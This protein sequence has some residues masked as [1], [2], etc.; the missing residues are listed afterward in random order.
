MKRFLL[1]ALLIAA[2]G[3]ALASTTPHAVARRSRPTPS[4]SPTPV[5]LPTATPEPPN[6]A[7]PR[8]QA[9]IR[10]NPND[11]EAM[12]ELA[13]EY[14][15][16][17]RPDLAL[18]LTQHLLQAGDKSAQVYF[19]DGYAQQAQGQLGIAVADLEQASTLDPTNV[20][21]LADLANLYLSINR[22]S[23]AERVANRA[24]TFNKTSPEAYLSLGSVYAAES[25]YDDARIQFE[26]AFALDKTSTKPLVSIAQTY[27]AQNNLPLALQAV[28][29]ALV[30][31]PQSVQVL[32]MKASLYARQHDD[33]HASEAFDD[34]AVA[35]AT[36]DQKVAIYVQKAQYFTSEHKASQALAVYQQLLS[37]YPNV[38][39]TY[40]AYGAYLA[41]TMHQVDQGMQQWRKALTLD[42]DNE[43]AL[44]DMGEYELQHNRPVD[45]IAYLKHLVS[46]APS[47]DGYELL[48]AA[49]NRRHEFSL[50]RDACSRSFSIKRSPETLGCIAGADFELHNYREASQIFDVLDSAARGYLDQNPQLLF[51]AARAYAKNHERSKA[52][53][54]YQR[55]LTMM[56][57]GSPAYKSVQRAIADLNRTH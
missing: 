44:R 2:L 40:V 13:G 18:P 3:L 22:A 17:N 9:R 48:G 12:T 10:A 5:A 28:E 45:A 43:D 39:L 55:L 49:Y 42:P 15:S 37:R 46:V 20:S 50:Q 35:A 38:A 11:Q 36:D 7:I 47:A 6:I 25:H 52:L 14:L 19:L 24:V 57:R 31:D 33:A 29:R 30:V 56:Q 23:D 1:P 21:V 53:G 16:I 27:V 8:L 32:V 41:A 54:A 34:A 4:P 26:K 51:V